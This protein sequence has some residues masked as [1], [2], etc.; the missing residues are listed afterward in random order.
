MT[1]TRE[2]LEQIDE[3]ELNIMA[4]KAVG[5]NIRMLNEVTGGAFKDVYDRPVI[6]LGDMR[7]DY[8]PQYSTSMSEAATLLQEF[9]DVVLRVSLNYDQRQI[10]TVQIGHVFL[11][12]DKLEEWPK[13]ITQAVIL[14]TTG[15]GGAAYE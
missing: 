8:V 10:Y 7:Y 12:A 11:L 3:R 4:A 15:Q 14:A 13:I 6:D 9:D 2:L 1:Y 5:K